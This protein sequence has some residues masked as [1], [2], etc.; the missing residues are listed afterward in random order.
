MNR[1]GLGII[2]HSGSYDRIYHGLSFALAGLA[3]GRDVKLF[4]SYWALERMKKNATLDFGLDKEARS[5]NEILD[6]NIRE[7]HILKFGELITQVKKMGGRIYACT[8]SMGILNI[9]RN[10]LIEE[11][12]KSMGITTFLT[13]AEGCQLLFI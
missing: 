9:A 3:L 2:F 1:Q 11:V 7:G 10:E 12:E 6:K 13:E 5:H 8:S 4:F